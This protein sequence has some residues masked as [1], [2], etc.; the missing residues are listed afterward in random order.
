MGLRVGRMLYT[1]IDS[2]GTARGMLHY[3]GCYGDYYH[4]YHYYP[5]P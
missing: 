2:T 5:K 1:M 3:D 4:Y